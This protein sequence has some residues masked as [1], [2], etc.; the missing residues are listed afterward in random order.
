MYKIAAMGDKDS[1]YGFSSIGLEIFPVT[2]PREAVR[3]LRRE[4]GERLGLR[5][6]RAGEGAIV[7]R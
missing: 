4:M 5:P 2:E 6:L 7:N 3:E 1:I